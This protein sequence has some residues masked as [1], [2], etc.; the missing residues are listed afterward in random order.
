MSEIILEGS[1][2]SIDGSPDKAIVFNVSG[3]IDFTERIEILLSNDPID[4]YTEEHPFRL[5]LAI[6]KEIPYIDN[7]LRNRFLKAI[8]YF[9]H[10]SDN[11]KDLKVYYKCQRVYR[12]S[13][14]QYDS[15]DKI[16]DLTLNAAIYNII[17]QK[18]DII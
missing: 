5:Y 14:Q 18:L 10:I 16:T 2:Q 13:Y 17:R 4:G 15:P 12:H 9:P 6:T 8:E 1:L 7:I 3:A 11:A